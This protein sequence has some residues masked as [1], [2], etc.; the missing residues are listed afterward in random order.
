MR[1]SRLAAAVI[2]AATALL[3]PG[4]RPVPGTAWW[5]DPATGQL[6]AAVDSTV[7]GPALA[8]VEATA[9]RVER[10]PGRFTE[11]LSGGDTFL[12]GSYRCTVG[13]NVVDNLGVLYF[14]TAAHCVGAVGSPVPNIGVVTGRNTTYDYAIVKYTNPNIPKPGNVTLHNGS[15]QDIVP[16]ASN[17]LVGQAVRRSGGTTG[18]RSGTITAVNVTVNYPSGT[19]YGLIRTNICTEPGDSGAPLFSGTKAIGLASGGSGNCTSGGISFYSPVTRP[20]SAYGVNVY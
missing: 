19:V 3:V 7:T 15:F 12:N 8:R 18:V 10:Y 1:L 20:L 14:L 4:E 2:L 17:G 13:F 11:H 5:T 9:A 16:P 6:T